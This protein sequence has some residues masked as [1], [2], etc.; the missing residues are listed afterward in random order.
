[1]LADALDADAISTAAAS[2]NAAC[3]SRTIRQY[4]AG[5]HVPCSIISERRKTVLCL[6]RERSLP[7]RRSVSRSLRAADGESSA[8]NED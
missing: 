1:M 4:S 6:P 3:F 7:I 2:D 5:V 8:G